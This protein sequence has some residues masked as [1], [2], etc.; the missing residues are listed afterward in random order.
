MMN[1]EFC[2]SECVPLYPVMCGSLVS[3]L[4]R[5]QGCFSCRL[6]PPFDE[7]VLQDYY[8]NHYF[9]AADWEVNKSAVLA[10]D[11]FR[12]VQPALS[13]SIQARA[14]EIGAGFGHFA[15]CYSHKTSSHVDVVEPSASCRGVMQ[16]MESVGQIFN[17]LKEVPGNL[18]YEHVFCFHVAEHLQ[19]FCGF[20]SQLRQRMV[21][22]G[23]LFILTPNG[24][25]SSFRE[26]GREWGWSCP[27]QHYQFLSDQIPAEY[28][29]RCGFKVV[30]QRGV[31]PA[32]IHYPS[33][34]LI[35]VHRYI[36]RLSSL[37]AGSDNFL[38]TFS[39]KCW[40]KI[41]LIISQWLQQNRTNYNLCAVE[42]FFAN[43]RSKQ[44]LD[45]LLLVLEKISNSESSS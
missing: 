23:R 27:D 28:F 42:S 10:E 16:S 43:R 19:E 20:V 9:K 17:S 41:W 39:L 38:F 22:G 44:S 7:E 5:C 6:D 15:R 25:A 3:T 21:Q 4:H 35:G 45:E 36:V 11:Y 29:A 18:Q 14:L 13:S 33:R 26:F 24:A 12:K 37:I 34:W 8:Q 2:H 31:C 32:V 40:R 1:C 30:L